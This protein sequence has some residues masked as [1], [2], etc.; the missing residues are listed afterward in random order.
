MTSPPSFTFSFN[1]QE[2]PDKLTQASQHVSSG[3]WQFQ[4][5]TAEPN[6]SGSLWQL[7]L[8][9]KQIVFSGIEPLSWQSLNKTLRRYLPKLRD[10]N[11][12]QAIATIEQE[13]T[14]E[15]I[16]QLKKMVD[17]VV[18]LGLMTHQEVIEALRSQ[19]LSDFD[20]Y[21]FDRAGEAQFI[22]NSQLIIQTPIPGFQL[23][24]LLVNAQR[25]RQE[26]EGLKTE[27]PS[28][29][30]VPSLNQ[31][32]L[33]RS[34]LPLAQ[35]QQ[36]QKLVRGGRN[37]SEIAYALAKDPLDIAKLFVP[38]I[39][40]G[41]V[42]VDLSSYQ[43]KSEPGP[44]IFIVDDSPLL[45]QQF[46]SVVASWGYQVN[47]CQNAL[48]AVNEMLNANPAAIFLDINMPG[49]SGFDLIKQIRRQPQLNSIPL[50]LLTAEKS[51]SNQFRAQW[52]GC[53]F[54]S[55]PR[56]TEEIATFKA[57]LR[58]LLQELAPLPQR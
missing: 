12:Q 51:M 38:M 35:K 42:Q 5:A 28:L 30:I 3:Y 46:Q 4:L 22:P 56:A 45:L 31:E 18:K 44:E 49:A 57:E 26:W 8:A 19:I 7:A 15:E 52:A 25:R 11:A 27:I 21:L 17:K 34:N 40:K 2:L 24:S 48:I 58:N 13:S 32:L 6:S 10:P 1:P 9:Q 50:V 41:L 29:A 37:F 55:K 39:R 54:L 16:G 20:T 47:C 53:R 33:E 43:P 14:P 36:L 23:E